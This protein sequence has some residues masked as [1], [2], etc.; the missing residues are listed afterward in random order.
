MSSVKQHNQH[1]KQC[2]DRHSQGGLAVYYRYTDMHPCWVKPTNRPGT[3]WPVIIALVVTA[4]DSDQFS[5][6]STGTSFFL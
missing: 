6:Y 4:V 2:R 1:C 5:L 3:A